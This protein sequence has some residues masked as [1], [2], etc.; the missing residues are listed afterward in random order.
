MTFRR[1]TVLWAL[2]AALFAGAS[3]ADEDVELS[4]DTLTRRASA[5]VEGEVLAVQGGWN[6]EATRI[7]TTVTLLVDTV[8][9]GD[10][11]QPGSLTLRL[12]GGDADGIGFVVRGRSARF[13]SGE[14]VFLFLRPG[15]EAGEFPLV[16]GPQGKFLVELDPESQLETLRNSK[17]TED[18]AAVIAEIEAIEGPPPGP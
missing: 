12:Q 8:Y 9:K 4:I 18:K 13:E 17:T 7:Y 14:R 11:V 2:L 6:P 5:I 15:F 10:D 1:W 3:R 16:E